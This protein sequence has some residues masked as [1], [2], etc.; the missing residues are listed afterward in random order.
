MNNQNYKNIQARFEQET[1]VKLHKRRRVVVRRVIVVA[2][3]VAAFALLAAFTYPLFSPL[4]GDALTLRGE[5][6]GN[7]IVRITVQNHAQ[8][9]LKLQPQVKLFEWIT[10]NEVTPGEGQVCFSET[11]I[12]AGEE[13]HIT[14]DLSPVYDIGV[15]EATH[16]MQ[17]HYLVLTNQGFFRGQ[18]WKC[19]VHFAENWTVDREDEEEVVSIEAG[20]LENIEPELQ[21]YFETEDYAGSFSFNPHHYDYLQKVEEVL[22]RSGKHIVQAIDAGLVAEPILD[23][24]IIDEEWPSQLQYQLGSSQRSTLSDAFGRLVGG[25]EHEHI[26]YLACQM[27][28]YRE[29]EEGMYGVPLLYFSTFPVAEIQSWE[30]CA[31][32]HGRIISFAELEPWLVYRDEEYVCYNVTDLFYTDLRTYLYA[33]ALAEPHG[34]NLEYPI[35]EALFGRAERI[36]AYYEEN[37][38]VMRLEEYLEARPNYRID[39]F[40]GQES[41]RTGLTGIITSDCDISAVYV[42][43]TDEAGTEIYAYSVTPGN[44]RYYDLAEATEATQ[45]IQSLCNGS[46]T[47]EIAVQVEARFESYG[48]VASCILKP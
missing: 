40:S 23:G 9:D 16:P 44:P 26:Q 20:I 48:A 36:L 15:L 6:L 13:L 21:Y 33:Y 46:Y 42:T 25:G 34:E 10:G 41:H 18:Q 12:P 2:A 38:K 5:Y 24:V 31:F 39:G 7:G 14:L 22:L 45:F 28:C 29:G 11:V 35:N 1:G 30:D 3:V 43:V 8:K 37:L 47:L 27:P 4:D 32:I 19:T 17:Y